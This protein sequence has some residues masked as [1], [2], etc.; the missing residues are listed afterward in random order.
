M[1]IT[2]K[3]LYWG[4]GI[5]TGVITLTLLVYRHRTKIKQLASEAED[6]LRPVITKISSPFGYRVNPVTKQ[7]QFHNGIDLPVPVNTKIKSPMNGVVE[8]VYSN[9]AGGNQLIIKHDN[10]YTTGYAH[11]TKA[12][13][14]KGDKVKQGDIVALS[15]NTGKSTG[16]HLHFT[17]KDKTGNWMDPAKVIYSGVV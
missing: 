3:Q 5:S 6:W 15:G 16:P 1:T 2:S 11:L 4:L 10:G 13:L 14:K 17:L 9:P 12:L 7:Q 8:N